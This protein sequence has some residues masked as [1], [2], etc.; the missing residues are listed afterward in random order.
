MIEAMGANNVDI[1]W[2]APFAYI[3]AKDKFGTE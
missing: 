3:L 2:L 1:G